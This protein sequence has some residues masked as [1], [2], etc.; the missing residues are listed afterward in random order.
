MILK[1]FRSNI[2]LSFPLVLGQ[3]GQMVM[4]LIDT[5]MVGALG[6]VPVAACAFGTSIANIFLLIGIGF[7]IPVQVL[8]AKAYGQG[9]KAECYLILFQGIWVVIILGLF[10]GIL[11]E[12]NSSLLKYLKQDPEVLQSS[13]SYMSWMIWGMVPAL[14]FQ[15]IKNF[16]EA[17]GST[18]M[19]LAVL[20]CG[21]LLNI[22]LNSIFIYGFWII[23]A[24]GLEGAGIATFLSRVLIALLL[25]A[26]LVREVRFF[27]YLFHWSKRRLVQILNIG[28]PS[29]IQI[30]FEI[31]LFSSAAILMG[32]ISAEAQAAHQ[33]ALNIAAMAF[34]VPLG[35]SFAV[36][37]RVGQA[38]GRGELNR[39]RAITYLSIL[40]SIGFMGVY[41]LF[42]IVFRKEIAS[43]FIDD[44]IVQ[45]LTMKLLVIAAAFSVFDAIQVT[46][47]GGL[48]GLH[49][50]KIPSWIGFLVYWV[51]GLSIAYWLGLKTE[52]G[53]EGVWFGLITSLFAASVLF[54]WRFHHITKTLT[55]ERSFRV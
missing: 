9:R 29:A 48:R 52:W 55:I 16:L 51:I 12:C 39:V 41:S 37:I 31:G 49:D 7:C 30:F 8:V 3:L 6:V 34:M 10:C 50:V 5:K 4:A 25:V 14:I 18:W 53:A 15:C 17:Q 20:G 2:A 33:I 24:Y 26:L 32:M 22:I 38:M 40:Q 36:S 27:R 21:V 23:P 42:I 1:E 35:I 43:S 11:F 54:F 45:V 46:A 19:P 47:L 44:P 13:Y 28:A